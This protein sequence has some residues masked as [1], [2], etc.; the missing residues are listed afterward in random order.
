MFAHG[1]LP[2]RPRIIVQIR[3]DANDTAIPGFEANWD[4]MEIKVDWMGMLSE[5]FKEQKEYSRRLREWVCVPD[6]SEMVDLY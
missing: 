5:W 4:T 2:N 1:S 3:H 6:S